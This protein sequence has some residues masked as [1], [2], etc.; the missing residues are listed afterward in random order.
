MNIALFGCIRVRRVKSPRFFLQ[1]VWLHDRFSLWERPLDR[2]SELLD[3]R[4]DP[5]TVDH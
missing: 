2:L 5:Q 4:E 3:E 1:E